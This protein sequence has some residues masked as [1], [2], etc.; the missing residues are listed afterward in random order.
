M[1]LVIGLRAYVRIRMVKAIGVDDWLLW[2]SS[3]CALTNTALTMTQTQL[4]L[5]LPVAMR[6]KENLVEYT[7][8]NFANRPI[9]ILATTFFKLSL[10]FSY[11]RII[12]NSGFRD[13]R[14]AVWTGTGI[15]LA[16]GIA[17]LF[18]IFFAC[19]PVRKS[20]DPRVPGKCFPV[21][22]FYYG[23][24][25]VNCCI[26][27]MLFILPIP[28]LW[29]LQM[30]K[31][32]KIGLTFTFAL[33]TFTTICSIMRAYAVEKVIKKADPVD[34]VMWSTVEI[35]VGIMT[36]SIPALAP[37]LKKVRA[38][39]YGSSGPKIGVNS[40]SGA[41]RLQGVSGA[42]SRPDK[43]GTVTDIND[44]SSQSS[45]ENILGQ[46]RGDIGLEGGMFEISKTVDMQVSTAPR[47]SNTDWE[48]FEQERVMPYRARTE[49]FGRT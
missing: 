10:C 46:R 6:P 43:K 18:A 31:R 47:A 12:A 16:F 4:G 9:Y 38:T 2:I 39:T 22:P 49:T 7:V 8:H 36:A 28:L 15:T 29:R 30:N 20:W 37:L 11:M 32:R 27:L 45:Q 41:I 14:I 25:I 26:D 42:S 40:K 13:Y 33:G 34:F 44:A 3:A 1:T 17:Y 5:G 48:G 24:S 21:A 35:N 19:D 23:T